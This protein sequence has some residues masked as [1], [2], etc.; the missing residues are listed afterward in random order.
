MSFSISYVIYLDMYARSPFNMSF[1]IYYVIYLD[2]YVRSPFNMSFL[3]S[4]SDGKSTNPIMRK[5]PL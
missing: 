5:Y 2:T 1:L 3:I 4:P